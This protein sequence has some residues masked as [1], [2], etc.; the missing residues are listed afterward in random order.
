MCAFALDATTTTTGGGGMSELIDITELAQALKLPR[1]YVRDSLVKK[2]DFPR[3][4]LNLSQRV[5]KWDAQ[6]VRQW[7]ERHRQE[8]AR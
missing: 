3:P 6:D 4:A 5:R 7:I 2:P 1:N 8:E